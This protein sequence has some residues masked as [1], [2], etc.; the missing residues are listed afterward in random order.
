MNE[1]KA[2]KMFGFLFTPLC[3]G[4]LMANLLQNYQECS[5]LNIEL[6]PYKIRPKGHSPIV[7]STKSETVLRPI[8]QKRTITSQWTGY[9]VMINYF[10]SDILVWYQDLS[11]RALFGIERT[12]FD[13]LW[14]D[15]DNVCEI[16][17]VRVDMLQ[18]MT[19]WKLS[20]T[21]WALPSSIKQMP[22][23][24]YYRIMIKFALGWTNC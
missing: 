9:L 3:L 24:I 12:N 7:L 19:H 15:K 5:N 1:R 11:T 16:I 22:V 2:V 17:V 14:Q 6:L 4:R 21:D 23:S 10:V 13:C 20:I 8:Q 18:F